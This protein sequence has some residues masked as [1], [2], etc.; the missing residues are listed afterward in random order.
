M[1][2]YEILRISLA[3]VYVIYVSFYDWLLSLVRISEEKV[4]PQ[5]VKTMQNFV[6]VGKAKTVFRLIEL[7]AKREEEARRAGKGDPKKSK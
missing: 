2:L 4:S 7:K 5:E 1:I 6:L 3:E